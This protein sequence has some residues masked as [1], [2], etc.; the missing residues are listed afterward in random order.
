MIVTFSFTAF[1]RVAYMYIYAVS[2]LRACV[3]LGGRALLFWKVN[4][5]DPRLKY[6]TSLAFRVCPA[7]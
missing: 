6:R 1:H 2:L 3:I 5:A 4:G 7:I